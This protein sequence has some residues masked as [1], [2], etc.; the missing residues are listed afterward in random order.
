MK[1]AAAAIGSAHGTPTRCSDETDRHDEQADALREPRRTRVFELGRRLQPGLDE[2]AEQHAPR[3]GARR[4]DR[5]QEQQRDDEQQEEAGIE[6]A[7]RDR[8]GGDRPAVGSEGGIASGW[9]ANQPNERSRCAPSTARSARGTRRSASSTAVMLAAK[10]GPRGSMPRGGAAAS[11]CSDIRCLCRQPI[12]LEFEDVAVGHAAEAGLHDAV[13]IEHERGRCLQDVEVLG[14]VGTVGEVD[15]E[16]ADA[17]RGRRR[18]PRACGAR[19]GTA[20][21]SRC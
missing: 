2:R 15:V 5:P 8:R 4:E 18:P 3:R 21:R 7:L 12:E 19:R 9:Y 13:A 20:S 1:A 11:A 16:V 14:D 10:R 17:R 6:D